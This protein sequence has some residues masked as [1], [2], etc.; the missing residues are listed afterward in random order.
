MDD[1]SV[2]S[3]WGTHRL[4]LQ[5]ILK[6]DQNTRRPEQ[7]REGVLRVTVVSVSCD[8]RCISLSTFSGSLFSEPPRQEIK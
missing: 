6:V 8:W 2:L 5:R 4:R 3:L 1:D 7:L